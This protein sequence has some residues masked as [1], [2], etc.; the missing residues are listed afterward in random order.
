[1]VAK[2]ELSVVFYLASSVPV[3]GVAV[4]SVPV[5]GG[6]D[7][8]V[9]GVVV[10]V[11]LEPPPHPATTNAAHTSINADKL[12]IEMSPDNRTVCKNHAPR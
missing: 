5:A 12:L 8:V 11:V 3:A 10:V 1:M 2:R 7:S 4:P 9:E 6:V